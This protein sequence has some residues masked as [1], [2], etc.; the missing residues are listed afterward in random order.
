MSVYC[1]GYPMCSTVHWKI[2]PNRAGCFNPWLPI[3]ET[4]K[5]LS[6]WNHGYFPDEILMFLLVHSAPTR[7]N[8]SHPAS[9][10]GELRIHHCSWGNS[11]FSM[12]NPPIFRSFS[13][14]FSSRW[15]S[16][17]SGPA[18][19]L[20]PR[21]LNAVGAG[22]RDRFGDKNSRNQLTN[23]GIYII[24]IYGSNQETIGDFS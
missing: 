13:P 2:W 4:V 5:T 15:T 22:A 19:W 10:L 17:A 12:A 14:H 6:W 20:R 18:Q 11:P 8:P 9:I 1:V 16:P 3:V 21:R 24:Y 23:M 7:K